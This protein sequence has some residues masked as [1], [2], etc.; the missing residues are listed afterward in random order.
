MS[1]EE[2]KASE[3]FGAL[4]G[5][6]VE[7]DPEQRKRQKRVKRRA[8]AISISL[9]AMVL[10]AI[11]LLP[12][13][14]KGERIALAYAVPI[15]PYSPYTPHHERQVPSRPHPQQNMCHFCAPPRIPQGIVMRDKQTADN[16]SDTP[17]D[18]QGLTG[19][20]DPNGLP[21]VDNRRST[22]P[23]PPPPDPPKIVHVT[24]LDPAML[25]RRIEPVYPTLAKQTRREGR[26]ELH[27]IIGTDGTIQALQVISGDVLFYQSAKDAV[28]QWRYKPT[29][30]NHLPVEVDTT[31]TVIYTLGH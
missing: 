11:I 6:F 2:R 18:F 24:T 31:I 25:M 15:P 27:A 14:G 7:G 17:S 13:F 29:Y 23:P 20:G 19:L 21:I 9:Q 8:L 3:E 5:C 16:D 10:A 28:L 1:D 22:T 12:L 26:V 4:S 30:L